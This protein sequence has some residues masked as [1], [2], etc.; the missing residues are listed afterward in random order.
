MVPYGWVVMGKT[1]ESKSEKDWMK[2]GQN[3]VGDLF[4]HSDDWKKD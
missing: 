2:E 4:S 1:M 3:N